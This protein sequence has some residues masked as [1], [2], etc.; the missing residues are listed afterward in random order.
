MTMAAE[1]VGMEALE[2]QWSKTPA[3]VFI[4]FSTPVGVR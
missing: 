4:A 2:W 3:Q 1:P